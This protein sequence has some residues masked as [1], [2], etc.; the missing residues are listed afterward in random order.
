MRLMLFF[1]IFVYWSGIGFA[2][3][4]FDDVVFH[5]DFGGLNVDDRAG[6]ISR[7][8]AKEIKFVKVAKLPNGNGIGACFRGDSVIDYGLGAKNEL[9]IEGSFTYHIRVKFSD[10][11][12]EQF[13][14]G[15]FG[16]A[17]VSFLTLFRGFPHGHISLGKNHFGGAS[18]GVYCKVG[19][20]YDIFFRFEPKSEG[21]SGFLRTSVYDTRSGKFLG[22]SIPW[23]SHY[24]KIRN[25]DTHFTV[26]KSKDYDGLCGVVEQINVWRRA[27]SKEEMKEVVCKEC[28]KKWGESGS[29]EKERSKIS[30]SLKCMCMGVKREKRIYDKRAS[31]RWHRWVASQKE[32]P[33]VA[34]GYFQRYK[35][36]VE[37]YKVYRD[38]NLSIVIAPVSSERNA[39]KVGLE[40]LI[41][42]WGE[43]DRYLKLHYHPEKLVQF[44]EYGKAHK[45]VTGY[46][47]SD[48]AKSKEE[49]VKLGDAFK[50]IY[51][52][53]TRNLPINTLM[54]Y[55][56]S[57]G[58]GFEK[59][60]ETYMRIVKPAVLLTTGYVLYKDGVTNE[61]RFYAINEVLREKALEGDIGHMGFVLVTKHG[62]YRQAS[63]SD[64][65]WQVN[66][67]LAYGAKGIWYY[68]YR[69]KPSGS[70]SDGLV[71]DKDDTPTED[72][73]YVRGI[74]KGLDELWQIWKKLKSV[75]V[76]HT[77]DCVP[78]GAR[79]YVDGCIEGIE[80]LV[81]SRFVIGQFA[82]CV[83]RNDKDVYVM[84]VNKRFGANKKADDVT[85]KADLQFTV[86]GKYGGV[87]GY[88]MV[89]G[90]WGKLAGA[91]GR[92]KLS[93]NGGE[94]K[95]IKLESSAD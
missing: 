77:S 78:T 67:L 42:H 11:K 19:R 9:K 15:R 44:V 54:S 74:N 36:T 27:L 87:Y 3:N 75:C 68:N 16:D 39:A 83:D 70:Y 79:G 29:A 33:T 6:D 73:Y 66:S 24:K 17:P 21:V 56:F 50:Y 30:D 51:E 71:R 49:F 61:N 38:A 52:N 80:N 72:Y 58:G 34:W 35:G 37:E 22:E 45:S 23:P 46:L 84:F 76:Y 89:R 13:I 88:D 20:F 85:L 59:Y 41:G 63:E 93:F 95:L 53:D 25:A 65:Y 62:P 69:I 91:E 32:F 18:S 28:G 2:Q 4:V 26:G 43:D 7:G 12:G 57:I 14:M 64:L 40:T 47:L 5:V 60:I 90:K 86:S 31:E 55:P 10:T 1:L 92:Y 48:E 82:N 8:V 94:G 81:G